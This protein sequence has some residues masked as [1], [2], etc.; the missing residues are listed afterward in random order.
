M[1]HEVLILSQDDVFARML[2]LELLAMGISVQISAQPVAGEEAELVLL[3]LDSVLSNR[4]SLV[5]KE[6]GQYVHSEEQSP[7]KPTRRD[8]DVDT[9]GRGTRR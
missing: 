9:C 7:P 8:P 4:K 1:R 5:C 6:A 3:D 2:Q